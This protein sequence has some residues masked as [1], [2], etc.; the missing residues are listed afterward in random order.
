MVTSNNRDVKMTLSVETLGTDEVDRLR[1]EIEA[2]GKQGGD[3][4][5]E[6]TKLAAEVAKLGEQAEA[7]TSFQRLGDVTEELAAKQ[8]LAAQRVDDLAAKLNAAK[9]ATQQ[10]AQSQ[11]DA[12]DSYASAQARLTEINGE[13]A[14][15]RVAYD[16][17]GKKTT[18]YKNSVKELIDEKTRL[19]NGTVDLRNERNNANK[20]VTDAVSA[21]SKLQKQ[22]E[23]ST[24]AL[25]KA[26]KKLAEARAE[27]EQS[28]AAVEKLGVSTTDVAQA[29]A[30]LVTAL[31][32]TGNAAKALKA[33][34]DAAAEAERDLAQ[35]AENARQALEAR[36][37]FAQ[38]TYAR[39]QQIAAQ[40]IADAQRQ[41]AAEKAASDAAIAARRAEQ[42]EFERL[43]RLQEQGRERLAA[44]ARQALLAEQAAQRDAARVAVQIENEKRAAIEASAKAQATAISNAFQSVGLKGANELRAEIDRVRA[45]MQ[46]LSTQAGLTGG[47]LRSAMAAGNSQIKELERELREVTGQMTL[48]D[49]AAGVLKNSMG[50]IAA[51]NLV[52][53]AIGYLV[54]KVKEM[55]R[56][57]I[58]VNLQADTL[59]RGLNAIYKDTQTTAQQISFLRNTAT[60]AGVSISGITNDF[61][62]FSAAT[63]ASNIPLETT[64]KVF[65]AVTRAASSLGLGA[66]KTGLAL[67][68]L[69]QIAS[70]G[71]VS[72]EELRQQL[73][74]AIPGALTLTAKG[75]GI[76]DAELIK[77]V[78]SGQLASR[79]FFPAFAEGLKEL[80]G[81]TDGLRQSWERFK[82]ALTV[83]AQNIGDAGFVQVLTAAL[84]ALS[85]VVGGITTIFSAFVEVVTFVIK[86]LGV[87]AGAVRTLTNP[88]EALSDLLL[89]SSVRQTALNDAF[90]ASI[91]I[92]DEKT[93]AESR[94]AAEKLKT[95]QA[96]QEQTAA[97][98]INTEEL[99]AQAAAA[100][101]TEAGQQALARATQITGDAG[102]EASSKWVKLNSE[103][104]GLQKQQE[105][106]ISVAEK[107]AKATQI[108][109]DA[110][111]A[112]AKLRGD[113]LG[114]LEAESQAAARNSTALAG[115]AAARRGEADVLAVQLK[116]LV[117][118]AIAQDGS[119]VKRQAEIQAIQQKLVVAREEAAAAQNSAAAMQIE[120]SQRQLNIQTYRDN[121]AAVA[122]YK[123]AL[124]AAM[125]TLEATRVAEANG[126]LSKQDVMAAERAA[127]EAAVLYNDALKDRITSANAAAAAERALLDTKV[128]D[129]RLNIEQVRAQLEVARARGNNVQAMELER[130]LRELE[131]KQ[132]ALTAEAKRAEA[133]ST[134]ALAEATRASQIATGQWTAS[135]EA[136]YQASVAKAKAL[137]NEAKISE[138]TAAKLKELANV[139]TQAGDSARNASGG[140]DQLASSLDNVASS[141]ERAADATEK[142]SGLGSD[143]KS[144]ENGS[145]Y[146][147]QFFGKKTVFDTLMRQGAT[148]AE[149]Q[150]AATRLDLASRGMISYGS[151]AYQSELKKIQQAAMN[152]TVLAERTGGTTQTA[153]SQTGGSTVGSSTTPVNI[154]ING[155]TRQINTA[156]QQDANALADLLRQLESSSSR[157][158]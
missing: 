58:E 134:M 15:L 110:L 2:L 108:E 46:T 129:L 153:A 123:A 60:Q 55:G 135:A 28:A 69:G 34:V 18:E 52:A 62:K 117:D 42:A 104:V 137:E 90:L 5:P 29:Q 24:A 127:A 22:Y 35:Q 101:G 23:S 157:A 100:R 48:A 144:G 7:L 132:L 105:Q 111:V 47:E 150:A 38:Q 140:Y 141:A 151:E 4:A 152:R 107:S 96:E 76:T 36:N 115:V 79:D 120:A 11:K 50:Q 61:V 93:A 13:L 97:L 80:Q 91:G 70:K 114:L 44:S 14:K 31:N 156:S 32:A 136:A 113:E 30:Q 33:G 103:M 128:S 102:L 64:N 51:G 118:L 119:T 95:K 121:S 17:A 37:Q 98:K 149:A 16:S 89:E 155:A 77:L 86:S 116:G 49:K 92:V 158:Y 148:A 53:D 82:N 20:A 74:D 146:S 39:D 131:L 25:D 145:G 63:K 8:A 88:M 72:M 143:F 54:E 154:T 106:N 45:A 139:T 125:V 147:Q 85:A 21:E 126:V 40:R 71:V 75:L 1:S 26:N 10:A 84:K 68:A 3:A 122:Q 87:L 109:G 12:A 43:Y 81:E 94:L 133:K 83:G 65:Q 56:A 41:A 57:F 112:L 78:E 9:S 66:D 59:R 142:T 19:K 124:D 67:N 6:F 99:K 73:G 27:Q 130:Q 138:L